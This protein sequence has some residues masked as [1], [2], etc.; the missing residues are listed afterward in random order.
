[1]TSTA[2]P[3]TTTS[4]APAAPRDAAVVAGT[5]TL[6]MAAAGIGANSIVLGIT[7]SGVPGTAGR[8]ADG[9]ALLGLAITAF[10]AVAVLDIVL[11]W[12]VWR[13]FGSAHRELPALAAWLRV[14]YAAVLATAVGHL[15][16]ALD[17]AT[18]PAPDDAAA[19]AALAQFGVTWQLGLVVFAAH[20]GV[21]GVLVLRDRATPSLIG[22]V[23]V[24]AGFAYAA[25]GVARLFVPDDAVLLTVLTGVLVASSVLGEVALGI[26]FLVRGGRSR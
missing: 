19:H 20:L 6:A 25:D 23:L 18:G 15:A 8:V 24:V 22:G 11:A 17:I 12:A 13:F 14:S 5:A 3:G 16:T 9:Q 1:M 7:G 26:W 21:L 4:P 10:L 2:P